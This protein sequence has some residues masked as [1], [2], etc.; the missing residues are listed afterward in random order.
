MAPLSMQ[1]YTALKSKI[2]G[3]VIMDHIKVV[4]P[5]FHIIAE[6]ALNR[7]Y[8]PIKDIIKQFLYMVN[9]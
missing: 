3:R 9:G 1:R 7:N 5:Q 6:H 4:I 8:L 2:Y